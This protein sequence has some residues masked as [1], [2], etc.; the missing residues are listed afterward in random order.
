MVLVRK[1]VAE[2]SL[3]NFMNEMEEQY[4][5]DHLLS[6]YSTIEKLCQ[7]TNVKTDA[8][9]SN[10]LLAYV[11]HDIRER[12]K[13]FVL[14]NSD[15]KQAVLGSAK[16]SLLSRRILFYLISKLRLSRADIKG[17][18][19]DLG[20]AADLESPA[21]F[22]LNFLSHTA[23]H[24]SGLATFASD[25]TW[26]SR[27]LPYQRDSLQSLRLLLEPSPAMC[28]LL[29]DAVEKNQHISAEEV[30]EQPQWDEELSFKKLLLAKESWPQTLVSPC[31]ECRDSCRYR[32]FVFAAEA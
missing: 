22:F 6:K 32:L 7:L 24:G 21:G 30:L 31:I 14:S 28:K 20:V 13:N 12:M 3:D 26:L 27:L 16:G 18:P 29:E 10:A 11:M 1:R 5:L 19:D 25:K 15:T 4:G 23:Y 2:A 9:L 8:K 17:C